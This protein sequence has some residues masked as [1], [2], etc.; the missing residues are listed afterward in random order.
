MSPEKLH[1]NRS[2]WVVPIVVA[3]IGAAGVIIAAIITT[4]NDPNRVAVVVPSIATPTPP[5]PPLT[6]VPTEPSSQPSL[7]SGPPSPPAGPTS[8]PPA[9]CTEL[10]VS[11]PWKL[12]A[13]D[14][15]AE[16]FNNLS[17]PNILRGESFVR[18]TYNLHGL[19][20]HVGTGNN[21]SAVVFN[22]NNA[23]YVASLATRGTNGLD[24]Q[25]TVDIPLSQFIGLPDAG[26][27][28]AG[29][30]ALHLDQDVAAVRVRIWHTGTWTVD[31]LR[32]EACTPSGSG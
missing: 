28:F 5:T 27:G 4:G 11:S 29:G 23:W 8:L 9:R 15:A 1:R 16:A 20:V 3:V 21:D 13:T 30:D 24:G 17:N 26:I 32:I 14:D 7:P 18:V 31:V 19:T 12:S 10:M 2:V 22:Q 6:V 25:Q